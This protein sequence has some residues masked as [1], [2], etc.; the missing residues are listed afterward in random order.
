MVTVSRLTNT[1]V[2]VDPRASNRKGAVIKRDRPYNRKSYQGRTKLKK[3]A[4]FLLK[5]YAGKKAFITITTTQHRTGATDRQLMATM[6][7]LLRSRKFFGTDYTLVCERQRNTGDLH[8]HI[9]ANFE[10]NSFVDWNDMRAK[11]AKKFQIEN[12]PAVLQFDWITAQN[13]AELIP[14]YMTK[15]AGY[16]SK[17]S[18]KVLKSGELSPKEE[19][20]PYSSMFYCRTFSVSKSL[21]SEFRRVADRYEVKVNPHSIMPI[22]KKQVHSNDFFSVYKSDDEI[23]KQAQ[24]AREREQKPNSSEGF[25]SPGQPEQNGTSGESNSPSERAVAS[26]IPFARGETSIRSTAFDRQKI[27]NPHSAENRKTRNGKSWQKIIQQKNENCISSTNCGLSDSR[28]I[29]REP[30][31]SCVGHSTTLGKHLNG[32]RHG[33]WCSYNVY[34]HHVQ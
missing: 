1:A 4:L 17:E 30:I 29:N 8:F 5:H 24:R 9:L 28:S 26:S 27:Q 2:A 25:C 21:R 16:C 6:G 12:H 10:E 32:R 7:D 33:G 14:R 20:A 18:G 13:S 31:R 34:L 15:V 19:D 11:I 22:L 3:A 23:F